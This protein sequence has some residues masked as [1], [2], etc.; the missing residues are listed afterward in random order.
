[1]KWAR[2]IAV[3]L[4]IGV[5]AY[6]ALQFVQGE[7]SGWPVIWTMAGL[8][9][10]GGGTFWI[11]ANNVRRHPIGARRAMDVGIVASLLGFAGLAATAVAWLTSGEL[12]IVEPAPADATEA[13][14]AQV[15]AEEATVD[16]GITAAITALTTLL[17]DPVGEGGVAAKRIRSRFKKAFESDKTLPDQLRLLIE[18]PAHAENWDSWKDRR[19]RAQQFADHIQV[20]ATPQANKE[21]GSITLIQPGNQASVVNVEVK[22]GLQIEARGAEDLT[23]SAEGLPTGLSIAGSTGLIGGRPS[24]LGNNSVTVT[25]RSENSGLDANAM[26]IWQI[27]KEETR[28][29]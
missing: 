9:A 1:M 12:D 17:I 16:V 29:P 27:T 15:K 24:V 22:G 14:K 5:G 25:A 18:S 2:A 6:V 11:G 4:V 3:A 28:T 20:S 26:F 21:P 10:I 7:E 19:M 23:Y 13:Q 8:A